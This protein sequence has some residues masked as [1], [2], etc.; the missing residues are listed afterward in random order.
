MLI[1]D[2][3][4]KDDI[5]PFE[6]QN[7]ELQKKH[8]HLIDHKTYENTG[9]NIHFERKKEF[10]EDLVKFLLKVKKHNRLK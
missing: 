6:Q 3:T 4:G 9:H 10:V 7:A 2:P 1:L 8:P 5:Q